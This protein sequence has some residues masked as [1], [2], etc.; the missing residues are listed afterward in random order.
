MGE[1]ILLKD[2]SVM[3][4]IRTLTHKPPEL[5]FD[6]KLPR[7]ETPWFQSNNHNLTAKFL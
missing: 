3:T 6:A 1:A 4:G 5:E 7:N 2:T